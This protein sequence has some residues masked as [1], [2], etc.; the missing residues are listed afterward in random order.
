[1]LMAIMMM[2]VAIVSAYDDFATWL[3]IYDA[4]RRCGCIN[5]ARRTSGINSHRLTGISP[6]LDGVIAS[7]GPILVK[8]CSN[9]TAGNRADDRAVGAAMSGVIGNDRAGHA[10]NDRTGYNLWRKKFCAA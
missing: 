10:A 9:Q 3:H 8:G 5:D 7:V 2:A 4:S 6:R 1:M